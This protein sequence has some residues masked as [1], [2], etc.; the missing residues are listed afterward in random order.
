M[1]TPLD[2]EKVMEALLPTI[3]VD[4]QAASDNWNL[5][6]LYLGLFNRLPNEEPIVKNAWPHVLCNDY[7]AMYETHP[8]LIRTNEHWNNWF[9]KHLYLFAKDWLHRNQKK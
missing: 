8:E 6:D 3:K 5:V 4:M 1:Q 9:K 2:E 7:I